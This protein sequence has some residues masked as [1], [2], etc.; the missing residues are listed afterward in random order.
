MSTMPYRTTTILPPPKLTSPQVIGEWVV[1]LGR[2]FWGR[3]FVRAQVCTMGYYHWRFDAKHGL[4]T[5][6]PG[7]LYPPPLPEDVRAM[8][9][10]LFAEGV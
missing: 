10:R 4:Y 5:R 9:L 3:R 1:S 8:M 6:G 2:T 7:Q